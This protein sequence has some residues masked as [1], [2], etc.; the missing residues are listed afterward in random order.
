MAIHQSVLECGGSSKGKSGWLW[1]GRSKGRVT[2]QDVPVFSDNFPHIIGHTAVLSGEKDFQL[3]L[4][5]TRFPTEE[6]NS[7]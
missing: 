7:V 2:L 6:G 4:L 1:K 3:R 5:W